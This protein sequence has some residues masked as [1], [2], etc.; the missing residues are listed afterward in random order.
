MIVDED[1]RRRIRTDLDN[2]VFVEAG[3]GSGKT[4]SLVERIV[5]LVADG[6]AIH[7][8]VAVTFTEKA[9]A[10]LRDRL[11]VEL[12]RG[13]HDKAL[14]DLDGAAIGTLHSFARRILSE[15]AVEAE[16]PPLVEVLDPVASRVA[17]DRR[18]D[19]LQTELLDDA[20]AA[21]VLRLAL[22]AD[23]RL[24]HIRALATAFDEDWDLV[25][26]RVPAVLP[27][28]PHLD[29]ERLR[30]QADDLVA[31]AKHCRAGDDRLRLRLDDVRDWRTKLEGADEAEALGV[32]A[33]VPRPHS[34]LGQ[35]GNW[36]GRVDEVRAALAALHADATTAAAT[37]LDGVMRWLVARIG[38]RIVADA[39]ARA[40]RSPAVP[41][42]ARA[43]PRPAAA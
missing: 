32:L 8:I 33:S 9:A 20:D 14:D 6:I 7:Y 43:R 23:V 10:E 3:A 16:L 39:S 36:N 26:E 13:G 27:P 2:T 38:R 34:R 1:A 18:Y 40:R 25:D 15:H 35:K 17:A 19:E 24:D 22:A 30:W 42:P 41:P 21:P 31:M 5:A 12:T 28:R 37:A 11:R 4:R 29:V